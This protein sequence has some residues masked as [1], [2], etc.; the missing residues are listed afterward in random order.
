MVVYCG[1]CLERVFGLRRPCFARIR[2][3]MTEKNLSCLAKLVPADMH[4]VSTIPPSSLFLRKVLSNVPRCKQDTR[5]QAAVAQI[6]GQD[7]RS[8]PLS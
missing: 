1:N 8:V 2:G 4:I 6:N 5:I 7:C 3:A